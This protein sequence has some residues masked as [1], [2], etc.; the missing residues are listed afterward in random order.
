MS[1]ARTL[2]KNKYEVGESRTHEASFLG[3][4]ALPGMLLRRPV[5]RSRQDSI[6]ELR[7]IHFVGYIALLNML[8]GR[9]LLR[10]RRDPINELKY[11]CW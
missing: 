4:I 11:I 1:P 10:T 7:E 3:Y 8:L 5:L 6:N 2:E 9:P